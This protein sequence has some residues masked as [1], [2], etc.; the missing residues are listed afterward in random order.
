MSKKSVKNKNNKGFTLIE[1]MV[2]VSIFAIVMMIAIGAVLAI[3]S[4]NKKAESLSSVINNLNF[5]LEAMNRDLR[6]G[7]DYICVDPT[8]NACG[9]IQF[10][11]SQADGDSVT[12]SFDSSAK[13]I[14]KT[15]TSGTFSVISTEIYIEDLKFY[16]ADE[17]KTSA[18]NLRQPKILLTLKGCAGIHQ[19][20]S[21]D[22]S[23]KDISIFNL[24]T[25]VTQRRLD[26]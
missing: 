11:S 23:I 2:A 3:V 9:G 10:S 15:D 26:I 17:D 7:Y 18:G 22:P 13:S 14:T 12:Y 25:L 24:Q 19:I 5:A 16:L 6:T 8:G 20:D 1:I 4:A 21:C